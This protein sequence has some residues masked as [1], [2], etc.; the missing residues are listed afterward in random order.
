MLMNVYITEKSD[1]IGKKLKKDTRS[2]KP[3][4]HSNLKNDW[5]ILKKLLSYN[6]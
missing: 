2:N 3:L 6:H 1:I 5:L 4:K